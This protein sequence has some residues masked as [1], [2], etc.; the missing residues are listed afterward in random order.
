MATYAIS[1]VQGC[2]AT[3]DRLLATLPLRPED[4]LWFVGDLVNR[5]PAS[6]DALRIVRGLGERAV[7]VLGNHD[8]HLVARAAR[9]VG[10]KKRDTLDDVLNAP[11]CDELCD[12]LRTRKLLHRAGDW[13]MV[14]GGLPPAWTAAAAQRYA[15]AAETALAGAGGWAVAAG[16]T[17]PPEQPPETLTGDRRHAAV[18]GLVTSLRTLRRDGAPDW[19]FKGAPED[20]PRGNVPWFAL[21]DRRTADVNIVFGHWSALGLHLDVHVASIDTGCVWGHA[22]TALRLDDRR[23]FQVPCSDAVVAGDR[24]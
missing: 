23:V 16:A 7:V 8:L 5:G 15:S 19:S 11:D 1:D 9:L 6:A 2:A 12:W 10:A 14:H 3:L 18:C 21:H 4:Q 17:R 13:V 22:L 20:A 24:E